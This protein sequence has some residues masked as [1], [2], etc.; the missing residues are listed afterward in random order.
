MAPTL[1]NEIQTAVVTALPKS[2]PVKDISEEYKFDETLKAATKE[3]VAEHHQAGGSLMRA[4]FRWAL[5]KRVPG[6]R[7]SGHFNALRDKVL[8]RETRFLLASRF[9]NQDAEDA[10]PNTLAAL[11]ALDIFFG[12]LCEFAGVERG[13]GWFEAPIGDSISAA[14]RAFISF[15]EHDVAA[16]G[17]VLY[18]QAVALLIAPTS[19][20]PSA[21]KALPQSPTKA[22]PIAGETSYDAEPA[23]PLEPTRDVAEAV[24]DMATSSP[25]IVEADPEAENGDGGPVGELREAV[26][27]VGPHR[28]GRVINSVAGVLKDEGQAF[29]HDICPDGVTAL[30]AKGPRAVLS[31]VWAAMGTSAP[32][33]VKRKAVDALDEADAQR[34]RPN[35]AVISAA[36]T[37]APGPS[38]S[39]D[40]QGPPASVSGIQP[41]TAA[42]SL[43]PTTTESDTRHPRPQADLYAMI[44]PRSRPNVSRVI[45]TFERHAGDTA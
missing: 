32:R 38:N 31:S 24:L 15:N 30:I 37:D 43:L 39:G 19:N 23:M 21:K 20:S 9:D 5:I 3:R 12:M 44:S 22:D 17:A 41:L 29:M 40:A 25:E 6:N 45:Q 26:E 7:P 4:A 10:I 42:T 36:T 34:S 28:L 16:S 33:G 8:S 27:R 13:F 2:T 18:S 14:D 11:D 35:P 1:H